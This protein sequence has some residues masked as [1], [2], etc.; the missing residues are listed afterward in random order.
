MGFV[1]ER[2]MIFLL[3]GER[4][5]LR[6]EMAVKP[7]SIDETADIRNVNLPGNSFFINHSDWFNILN[8]KGEKLREVMSS[9]VF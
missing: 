7:D 1:F 6:G 4:K 5:I 3:D 2:A 9:F 8:A